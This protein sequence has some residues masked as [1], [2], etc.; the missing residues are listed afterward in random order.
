MRM[1]QKFKAS[2]CILLYLVDNKIIKK[3][4]LDNKIVPMNISRRL[5]R[6]SRFIKLPYGNYLVVT[7]ILLTTEIT[8]P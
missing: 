7:N 4:Q 8:A 2:I 3:T 5:S 6:Y 1:P